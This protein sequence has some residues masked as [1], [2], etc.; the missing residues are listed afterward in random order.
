[1]RK[2]LLTL[3]LALSLA[4]GHA[5][6][7]PEPSDAAVA[8]RQTALTLAGAFSNEGFKLRDGFWTDTLAAG[9]AKLIQVNLCSGNQYWFSVGGAEETNKMA[10]YVY[11]EA[12][13]PL[14]AEAYQQGASAAAGYE[15]DV[16]GPYYIQVKNLGAAPVTF[17]LIYSYK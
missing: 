6:P 2:C 8:S 9:E 5:Q 11:D 14:A 4:V 17:C 3:T 7:P 12:G 1:M 13:K 15:A 10:V 16:S